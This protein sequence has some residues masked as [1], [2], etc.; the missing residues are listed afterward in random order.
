MAEDKTVDILTMFHL[1]SSVEH[2]TLECKEASGGL[3]RNLWDTYSAFAN[4][5]GGVI[6]LGIKEEPKGKFTVTGISN[7]QEMINIFWSHCSNPNI[8]SNNILSS[9]DVR[10]LEDISGNTD[11]C[12][13][14]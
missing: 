9:T 8:V 1:N 10:I 13:E 14:V 12:K 4:T 7:L 6:L 3:P 2:D 5:D 11:S